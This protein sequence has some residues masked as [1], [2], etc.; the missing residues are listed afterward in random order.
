[1]SDRP[2]F[3]FDTNTIVSAA[4]FQGSNPDR[5]LRLAL[6]LGEIIYSE[7]T[8]AELQSVL[9]REKFD[10]YLTHEERDLFIAKFIQRGILVEVR[11]Q[12]RACRDPRDD[13]FLALAVAGQAAAIVTGD[14]DLLSL[15]TFEGIAIV[16][17]A[18]FAPFQE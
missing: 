5:A 12:V 8:A 18:E 15:K 1:M 17:P 14:E 11:S 13:K 7:E 10:R 4:L 6:S 9:K 2:R 16:M 3:V